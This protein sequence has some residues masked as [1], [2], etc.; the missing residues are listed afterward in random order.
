[1]CIRDSNRIAAEAVI[2]G[3]VTENS[4]LGLWGSVE[5]LYA[6]GLTEKLDA[7]VYLNT[8]SSIGIHNKF[9]LFKSD[10]YDMA[11][12][13]DAKTLLLSPAN[14]WE[15]IPTFYYTKKYNDFDLILNPSLK[16]GPDFSG[17]LGSNFLAPTLNSGIKFKSYPFRVG[18]SFSYLNIT[19]N[20]FFVSLGGAYHF[21]F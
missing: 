4:A 11:V 13:I 15:V 2:D 8:N 5:L 19:N 12:G 16:F 7:G 21:D 6:R 10:S 9:Q 20:T 17:Q 3:I 18:L 14:G 1:M